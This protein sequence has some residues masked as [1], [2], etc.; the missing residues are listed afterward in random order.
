MDPKLGSNLKIS[1]FLKETETEIKQL[2]DNYKDMNEETDDIGDVEE[3]K[4]QDDLKK[5][6]KKL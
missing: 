6:V 2:K 4:D 5:W 1:N 3:N